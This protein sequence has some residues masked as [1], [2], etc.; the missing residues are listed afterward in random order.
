MVKHDPFTHPMKRLSLIVLCVIC[1]SL[2]HA[3]SI[4]STADWIANADY[5]IKTCNDVQTSA[6]LLNP[7]MVYINK[8]LA[9]ANVAAREDN[10]DKRATL[11][12]ISYFNLKL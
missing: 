1:G 3:Q 8:T 12:L 9:E 7:L 6:A 2:A 5:I 4:V 10:R 11:L